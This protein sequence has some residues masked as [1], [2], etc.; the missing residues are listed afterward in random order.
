MNWVYWGIGL[1]SVTGVIYIYGKKKLEEYIVKRVLKELDNQMEAEDMF[2][3][4]HKNSAVIKLVS[5]GKK[6]ECGSRG[7]WE[8]YVSGKAIEKLYYEFYGNKKKA[9]DIATDSIKGIKQDKKVIKK[10]ASYLAIGLV[11]II[12][13]VNPEIIIVG[14]SVV[15]QKEILDLAVK[16]VIKKA[17][18]PGRKTKIVRSDLGD[19]AT[20]IGAAMLEEK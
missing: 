8:Q 9:K 17:L 15:K 14:G 10:S 6:C 13:T 3:P 7:C 4:V 19:E 16:E 5:D 12:N 18:I 20:L 1:A 2:K 11:N